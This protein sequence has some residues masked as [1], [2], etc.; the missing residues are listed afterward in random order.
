MKYSL[1]LLFGKRFDGSESLRGVSEV[2]LDF[3]AG[4]C[5]FGFHLLA[6]FFR[7]DFFLGDFVPS[8][9]PDFSESSE[10]TV[11]LFDVILLFVIQMLNLFLV[12]QRE[13]LI[14]R[15]VVGTCLIETQL[16]SSE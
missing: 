13:H 8:P 5:V 10:I 12:Q 3:I 2:S 4:D 1:F 9:G 15:L 16:S 11:R 14:W 7:F 6:E